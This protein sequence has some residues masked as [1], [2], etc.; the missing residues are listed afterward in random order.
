MEHCAVDA[1]AESVCFKDPQASRAGCGSHLPGQ[2]QEVAKG[3]QKPLSVIRFFLTGNDPICQT[4]T[5]T[6]AFRVSSPRRTAGTLVFCSD[7]EGRGE[8]SGVLQVPGALF[9]PWLPACM[10]SVT[11][12]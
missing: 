11:F 3:V 9:F 12:G 10:W 7:S 2:D 1:V 5:F 4:E 6:I 8:E